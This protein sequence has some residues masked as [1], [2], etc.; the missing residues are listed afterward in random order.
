MP[1]HVYGEFCH[2][3]QNPLCVIQSCLEIVEKTLPTESRSLCQMMRESIADISTRIQDFLTYT[4][5][6]PIEQ[7][8][9]SELFSLSSYLLEIL[10]YV[11][12]TAL[13]SD[14]LLISHIAVGV[15]FFGNKTHIGEMVTNLLSNAITHTK[16][17]RYRD[18]TVVLKESCVGTCLLIR[19]T[20][21]GITK[22]DL[23]HVFERYYSSNVEKG[24][25][26]GLSIVKQIV[27]RYGGLISITSPPGYGT[28]VSIRFPRTQ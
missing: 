3:L 22:K 25:G 26:L 14:V 6:Q 16:D 8:D 11:D 13:E 18:I 17:S 24:H 9:T 2:S 27:E 7:V 23:P 20:G 5:I 12:I 19:D 21:T 4:S 10:E 15:M 28:F 1:P